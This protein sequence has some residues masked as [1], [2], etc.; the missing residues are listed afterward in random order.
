MSGPDT[1]ISM[2]AEDLEDLYENAPCGYLSLQ[3]DGRIAKVNKTLSTWIGIPAEQL[4][5][6]RLH[7]LLNTSGRIFYE[8]HFAP[9]LRMQ[10]FFNEVALDLVAADGRKLPVLANAMERRAEDGALLFTRVTMFQAAERRR[11]ERELVEARAAADTAGAIVKSQLDFE[12]Q[13]AELREQFIAILGHDLRNPLASI[14]AAGRMLRKEEQTDRS[15]KVLDLMQGSVVRMS[16]LIDNVLDFARA[17]L[18]GGIVLDRR[19]EELEPILRQVIEELRY[20]HL[21]RRIEVSIELGGPIS[22]DSSR[23][24]QLVSNLLG[25]ALTHGT[26]DEPV[27]LSAATVDGRLELWIA[28]GGAPISSDA[29]TR[30]FQPFFKGEAGTSQRGLGLG[31]YIASEIARAHG[32]AIT[33]SSGDNETRFTFVMPLD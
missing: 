21:D 12:Q 7:D 31:L 28:N 30:L 19:A 6:K 23:I 14:A 29:M 25:N 13:T 15:T 26:P 4:L 9:L 11:Y 10:G 16:G 33:V 20:S 27:R 32:G 24:G 5:G 2:P 17:R 8:T 22:C 18:G 1:Q 3:P